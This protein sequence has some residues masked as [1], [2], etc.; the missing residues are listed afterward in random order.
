MLR[1]LK[2]CGRNLLLQ[3]SC[4]LCRRAVDYSTVDQATVEES[5]VN[6]PCQDCQVRLLVSPR[7]LQGSLPMP[8]HALGHYQGTLRTLL[9]QERNHPCERRF[10]G[11]IHLLRDSLQLMENECLC[12][13]P[14][15][16]K[17]HANGLPSR[18][19]NA[20][21]HPSRPVLQR[22]KAG[23]SQHHLNRNMR[24]SNLHD[25]FE[26]VVA[27]KQQSK[28]ALWIVDDILTTG[29]TALSARTTLQQAGYEVRGLIC[30]A[31]TPQK[32]SGVPRTL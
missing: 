11:L 8:W 7:G 14:S 25:A 27:A 28:T 15:W 29:S 22:R 20:L 2:R 32:S 24:M 16:K 23:L 1:I 13:I 18:I 5:T 31:R 10:K 17:R 19:A 30:L 6:R 21:G 12:P 9:L 3:A 4:P 26:A